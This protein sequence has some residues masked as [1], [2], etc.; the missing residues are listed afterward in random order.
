MKT[1]AAE[2]EITEVL[3]RQL[4][5]PF[6]AQRLSQLTPGMSVFRGAGSVL[7]VHVLHIVSNVQVAGNRSHCF[8]LPHPKV[9]VLY[10]A[11]R[12]I[13]WSDVAG[14]VIIFKM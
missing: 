2:V 11:A 14:K 1:P 7:Q 13:R 12:E 6:G 9:C 10:T 8:M 4:R 5:P 3:V